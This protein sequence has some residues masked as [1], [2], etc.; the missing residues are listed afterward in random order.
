MQA[1]GCVQEHTAEH[2]APTGA[3]CLKQ[4]HSAA[5][6][7][8]HALTP[9]YPRLPPTTPCGCKS[10]EARGGVAPAGLAHKHTPHMAHLRLGSMSRMLSGTRQGQVVPAQQQQ[11]L[12]PALMRCRAGAAHTLP[13]SVSTGQPCPPTAR[14]ICTPL[15]HQGMRGCQAHQ[16]A[17]GNPTPVAAGSAIHNMVR[18]RNLLLAGAAVCAGTKPQGA[19]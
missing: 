17:Q 3:C 15:V 16:G 12:R 13:H 8:R 4:T 9:P 10:Q 6:Q 7:P 14:C 5:P 11:P 18:Q 2:T 1:A 19:R